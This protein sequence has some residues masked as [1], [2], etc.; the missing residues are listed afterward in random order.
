MSTLLKVPLCAWIGLSID[1]MERQVAKKMRVVRFSEGEL[2]CEQ[3]DPPSAPL[4]VHHA[5]A[6]CRPRATYLVLRQIRNMCSYHQWCV[7]FACCVVALCHCGFDF[8]LCCLL[9]FPHSSH[10]E[11]L[12]GHAHPHLKYNPALPF[13]KKGGGVGVWRVFWD[14]VS[15]ERGE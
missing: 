6:S 10:M 11:L 8:M 13:R 3:G 4:L 5:C 14:S 7:C 15:H 2:V 9:N 12:H 1:Q